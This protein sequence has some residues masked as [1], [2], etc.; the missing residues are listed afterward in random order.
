LPVFGAIC[1]G[2]GNGEVKDGGSRIEADLIPAKEEDTLRASLSVH[3]LTTKTVKT[4]PAIAAVVVVA[5]VA[6]V[7]GH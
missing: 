4:R 2:S 6:L 5:V 1:R 7:L 3:Y